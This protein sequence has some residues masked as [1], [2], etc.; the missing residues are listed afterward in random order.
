MQIRSRSVLSVLTAVT[1]GLAGLAVVGATSSNAQ[2]RPPAAAP[3][4]APDEAIA[5][6]SV[7]IDGYEIAAFD[8]VVGI[9]TEAAPPADIEHPDQQ[10]A[11][12]PAL[13][14]RRAYSSDI[15]L[16]NWQRAVEVQDPDALRDCSLVM[17]NAAGDPISQYILTAAYP[18]RIRITRA[19]APTETVTFT[20][21][22]VQ[23]VN[24]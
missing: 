10:P 5:K 16:S 6:I 20:A 11:A 7:L 19:A 21:D 4:A 15:T 22:H 8:Q 9:T 14:L 17:Y 2:D 1:V 3:A 13:V 18:L 24:P 23:R 12:P